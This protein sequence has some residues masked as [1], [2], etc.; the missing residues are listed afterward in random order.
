MV[1][2]SRDGNVH[3][4]SPPRR[5]EEPRRGRS[6]CRRVSM[7]ARSTVAAGAGPCFSS[8]SSTFLRYLRALLILGRVSNLPTVWS[9]CL[10]G[11]WLG[12][13]HRSDALPWLFSG[14]SLLY[15]G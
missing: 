5:N 2:A 13:D 1:F 6:A 11:W 3:L 9:N 12:G 14:A 7:D 8:L 10:A 4:G 15:T